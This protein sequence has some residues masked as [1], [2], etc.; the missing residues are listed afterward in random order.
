MTDWE[1]RL[2]E[3]AYTSPGGTR[4]TFDYEDVSMSITKKT[5][6]FEFPDADGTYVQDHGVT[7]RRYPLRL[8]FWGPNYDLKSN[9]FLEILSERGRGVLEHPTYGTPDVVPFGEITRRDDLKTAANQAIFEVVFWDSIGTAYPAGQQ[10]AATSV[11]SAVDLYNQAMAEQFANSLDLDSVTERISFKDSYQSLLNS[12]QKGLQ[13]IADVQAD[14]QSPFDDLVDGI[15]AGIDTFIRDP[16]ALARATQ[17]MIQLPANALA[18]ITRRLDAFGNL[19]RDIFGQKDAVS[20][21]GGVGGSGLGS[22]G[23]GNDSQEPNKFH[24]RNLYASTYVTGSVLSAVNAGSTAPTGAKA[25]SIV[26]T[27]ATSESGF[28]TKAEALT[29]AEELLDQ[30]AAVTAWRDANYG[31]LS[32]DGDLFS[33]DATVDTGEDYQQLQKAVALAAG[34]LVEISFVLRQEIIIVLDRDRT[35]MD[36]VPELYGTV[37]DDT[38]NFFIDS[39]DLTGDEHIEMK[40]GRRIAY[41]Q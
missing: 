37:D 7:G 15:N 18:S 16:L 3:A 41:Y 28:N 40:K 23:E 21:P 33:T 4:L 20:A 5:S 13:G 34:F 39:N 12:T 29:A 38:L 27:T 26:A 10:D 31:S 14:I 22:A 8:F 2:K 19:A 36:L 6:A 25:G 35:M 11:I 24:T 32:G 17:N 30:M 1:D 9:A